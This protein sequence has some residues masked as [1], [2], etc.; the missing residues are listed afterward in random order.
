MCVAPRMDAVLSGHL[1][2]GQ[3]RK[4]WG[5]DDATEVEVESWAVHRN[6]LLA[7]QC[8]RPVCGSAVLAP[9]NIFIC[10]SMSA[11]NVFA[12]KL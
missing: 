3:D 7:L 10:W 1:K 11:G 9:F 8:M 12:I 5:D 4:L 6:Y 2:A